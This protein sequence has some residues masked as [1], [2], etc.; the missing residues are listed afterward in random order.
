MIMFQG[1]AMRPFKNVSPE[2]VLPNYEAHE[3]GNGYCHTSPTG[4]VAWRNSRANDEVFAG[5]DV[6][7]VNVSKVMRM[8]ANQSPIYHAFP[9]DD[10]MRSHIAASDIDRH[11]VKK[12]P[13]QRRDEPVLMLL[14]GKHLRLVD[15]HHRLARRILDGCD[16][17]DALVVDAAILPHV[18][19]KMYRINQDNQ[20]IEVPPGS[21]E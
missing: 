15:G 20:W 4:W 7:W 11:F 6:G 5:S 13:I 10:A 21:V 9:I 12:M 1:G 18:T 19:V 8:I 3:D 14:D 16:S 17:V 2:T